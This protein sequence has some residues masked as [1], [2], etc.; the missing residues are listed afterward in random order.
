MVYKAI[1]TNIRKFSILPIKKIPQIVFRQL[2]PHLLLTG[3]PLRNL[4]RNKETLSFC[5]L[6]AMIKIR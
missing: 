3:W 1:R 5:L 6:Q 4:T 2:H